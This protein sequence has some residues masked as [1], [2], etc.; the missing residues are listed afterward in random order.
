MTD[1]FEFLE[2]EFGAELQPTGHQSLNRTYVGYSKKWQQ[3]IFV[4][5]FASTEEQKW[6]TESQINQQLNDRVLQ[7][8]K[9]PALILVMKDL[10]PRNLELPL[11]LKQ[12]QILGQQLAYFHQ[13]VRPFNKIT[14]LENLFLTVATSLPAFLLP[15]FQQFKSRQKLIEADLK[16]TRVI[17]GDVGFRNYQIVDKQICLIDFERA[18]VGPPALDL[19]KLYYQDFL[20]EAQLL[21]NFIRGYQKVMPFPLISPWTWYFLIFVT[22]KGIFKYTEKIDDLE[23]RK[24]GQE[25]LNDVTNFLS[26]QKTR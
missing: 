16:V 6:L 23:F 25:M 9:E 10:A 5:V 2:A 18:K 21:N 13:K 11:T 8:L 4:K 3:R 22:L 12:V 7:A 19:I 26:K 14:K 20:K 17:H 15:P 1:Q 24:I